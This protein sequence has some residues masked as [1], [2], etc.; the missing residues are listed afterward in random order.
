VLAMAARCTNLDRLDA[1]IHTSDDKDRL[2]S[3]LDRKRLC[4]AAQ[5]LGGAHVSVVF[6]QLVQCNSHDH[7]LSATFLILRDYIFAEQ[8]QQQQRTL[9]SSL[10]NAASSVPLCDEQNMPIAAGAAA[11]SAGGGG[12]HK[13]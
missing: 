12:K 7:G 8:Q 4:T 9:S 11:K 10:S 2:N 13:R 6:A 5:A 3:L 1:T